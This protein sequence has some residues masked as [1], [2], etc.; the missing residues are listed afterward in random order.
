MGPGD[1]AQVL[2]PLK[3]FWGDY[4]DP[5]LLVGLAVADDAAVYRVS[6]EQAIIQT[7]DFFTPIVD[8]PYAYGA[9]AAANSMSDVYAMGGEVMLALNIGGFPNDLPRDMISAIF[10]GAAQKVRE[11]GAVVAGGHTVI[12]EEPKFGLVITGTIHPDKILTLTGAQANDKLILTKALGSGI[13]STAARADGL[14]DESHLEEAV[15]LMMSLNRGAAAA[16]RKVGA[17]ACTDITG[18]GL[19]GHASEMASASGVGMR[20]RA[21]ALPMLT[22]T[23]DYAEKGYVT[24][25]AKRNQTF[26]QQVTIEADVTQAYIDLAWDPQTSGGL[27]IAVAKE[28]ADKLLATLNEEGTQAWTIGH[29]TDDSGVVLVNN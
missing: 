27:L 15:E 2:T 13:I 6:Q 12:D 8:D 14:S 21:S 16:L 23:L 3:S 29:V 5:N 26:F 22:G 7:V 1:L 24:A 11:A 20:I 4:Q 19:L 28:Q 25:G 18:F 9:I 10:M 17:H